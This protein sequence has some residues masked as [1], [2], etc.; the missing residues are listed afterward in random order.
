MIKIVLF[1]LAW[2]ILYNVPILISTINYSLV[3]IH[4]VFILYK[5]WRVSSDTYLV[6][7]I[8]I[9]QTCHARLN[10]TNEC[11]LQCAT[12]ICLIDTT[13]PTSLSPSSDLKNIFKYEIIHVHAKSYYRIRITKL[14]FNTSRVSNLFWHYTWR[15]RMLTT[16]IV[17]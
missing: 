4:F 5:Q 9:E 6:S 7:F 16:S 11:V 3:I 10:A 13:L 2:P 8:R 15:D 12:W 14:T 17:F 1:C